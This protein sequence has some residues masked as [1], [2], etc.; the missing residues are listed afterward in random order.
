MANVIAQA[1]AFLNKSSRPGHIANKAKFS[2]AFPTMPVTLSNV[3]IHNACLKYY[4]DMIGLDVRYVGL[5]YF[6]FGIW[7]AINDPLMGI[8][9]D[10]F[11]YTKKRGK[12]AYLMRVTAPVNTSRPYY[13]VI[14]RRT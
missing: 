13:E 2:L 4:T 12:Y 3:P 11:R 9:I 5:L 7:N 14:P 6:A 8:F 1:R 10:R